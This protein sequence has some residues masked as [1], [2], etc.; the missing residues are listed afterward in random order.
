M[1]SGWST[2]D[3]E[4]KRK[5]IKVLDQVKAKESMLA[6]ITAPMGFFDPLGFSTS[7]TGKGAGAK[8]PF[9]REVEIKHGRIAML[10]SLGMLVGEQFHPLFGATSMRQLSLLSSRRHS[11]TSGPQSWQ[12]LPSPRSFQSSPSKSQ[13]LS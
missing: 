11:R 13:S 9:Y 4:T 8:L 5:L 2:V 12:R 10:A 7:L 1:V 3:S 6:G